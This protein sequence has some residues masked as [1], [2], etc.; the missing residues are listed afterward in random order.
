MDENKLCILKDPAG[1]PGL[2]EKSRSCTPEEDKTCISSTGEEDLNTNGPWSQRTISRLLRNT[3]NPPMKW[4]LP[5]HSQDDYG[6]EGEEERNF[7][8]ACNLVS[9]SSAR[10]LRLQQALLRV[11]VQWQHVGGAQMGSPKVCV[12]GRTASGDGLPVVPASP[13][14]NKHYQS[15]WRLMEQRSLLLF[16]HEYTRRVQSTTAYISKVGHLLDDHL[17]ESHRLSSRSP[18]LCSSAKVQLVSLCQEFRIHLNHWSSLSAKVQSDHYLR[19][20][21]GLQNKLLEEI[22]QTLKLLGLQ[23]LVLMECYLHAVLFAMGQSDL[24]HMPSEVM[25][26]IVACTDLYN[27]VLEEQR[28]QHNNTHPWTKILK[29][30]CFTTLTNSQRHHPVV[31]SVKDL[32]NILAVHHANSAANR[33][34]SWT[35]QQCVCKSEFHT[36]QGIPTSLRSRFPSTLTWEQLQD[37]FFMFPSS[38]H[39]GHSPELNLKNNSKENG[40]HH[41]TLEKAT[42]SLIQDTNRSNLSLQCQTRT[43]STAPVQTA[44]EHN[45]PLRNFQH[46]QKSSPPTISLSGFFQQDQSKVELLF[47]VLVASNDLLAPLVS[48]PLTPTT[49]MFPHSVT[50]DPLPPNGKAD[51]NHRIRDCDMEGTCQQIIELDITTR[52]AVNLSSGAG[53]QS[54]GVA[55]GDVQKAEDECVQRPRSVQWLDLGQSLLFDD[56]LGQYR[57]LLWAHCSKALWLQMHVP[58]RARSTESINLLD[59]HRR[60][61]VLQIINQASET[62]Q[63]PRECKAMLEEFSLSML[64]SAAHAQWDYVVCRGLG[65]ALKDKCLTDGN[66]HSRSMAPSSNQDDSVMMSVTAAYL[67][68]LTPPL[69]SSLSHCKAPGSLSLFPTRTAFHRWTLSLT[70]AT[71]QL[72]TVWVMSK[73]CQFLSSWSLNKFLLIT[74]GDLKVLSESSD[75][76]VQQTKSL[77]MNS[78]SNCLCTPHSH[79]PLVLKQQLQKVDAASSEFQA[80]SSLV[81]KTFSDDCKRMSADLFEQTMPSAGHWRLNPRPGLPISPSEYASLAAQNVIGQVLDGVAL[82]SDEIRIQ[83]LSLTMT[84][85]MEAWMEHIL[86]QRIKFSVQGAL[87]LKQDFD[88]VREFI[89]SDRYGLPEE[90][91]QRLL[92][93]RVFQQVDSA[94]LCLLQQPQVRPYLQR[95]AWEPFTRCCPTKSSGDCLNAAVGSSITNLRG[96]EGDYMT[97]SNPSVGSTDVPS[98]DPFLPGEPYLA[99]SLALGAC[100]QDWLDLR[101]R[102]SSRRWRLPGLRCLSKSEP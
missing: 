29:Q 83:A 1:K 28:V 23:G 37:Q 60:F 45:S 82:L 81:L 72:S 63:L 94:V 64:V 33:L 18:H 90:L 43:Y 62:D 42:F 47:H 89:C 98:V 34:H 12:K 80:F 7:V 4:L 39:T 91:L 66:Q 99:P 84:A 68:Q 27:K 52:L 20:A 96:M 2:A 73:S 32:L 86:K 74:Q 21:L 70:L 95:R 5:G 75:K 79:N 17:R 54:P 9:R 48:H 53:Q 77:M 3:L 11:S 65:A 16:I 49:Q 30:I 101:I 46:L 50:I 51:S 22:R 92:S 41:P 58:H 87:Q 78:Y 44:L 14:L 57:T 71:V 38:S 93:L 15:L 10:I 26:D 25:A 88:S 56:L 6:E 102:T 85:F 31:V 36:K 76:M 35:G 24:D 40:Q 69:L 61:Q 59:N 55:V 13:F 97:Q 67:L 8:V 100:Q 19:R